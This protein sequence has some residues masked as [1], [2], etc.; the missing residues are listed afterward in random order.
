MCAR[1]FICVCMYVHVC[2]CV[3]MCVPAIS[4]VCVQVC[5]CVDGP[6]MRL[7]RVLAGV[8]GAWCVPWSSLVLPVA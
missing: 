3:C 6:L 1:D 2:A 7:N 4:Y 8:D 5:L